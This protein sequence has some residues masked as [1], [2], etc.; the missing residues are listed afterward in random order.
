MTVSTALLDQQGHTAGRILGE[1]MRTPTDHLG[2]LVTTR[3]GHAPSV[4]KPHDATA[5]DHHR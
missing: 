1:S 5:I 3:P 2:L 4:D